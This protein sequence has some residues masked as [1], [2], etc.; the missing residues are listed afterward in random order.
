MDERICA[1][2]GGIVG[3]AD[4]ACCHCGTLFRAVI[5]PS[6]SGLHDFFRLL[7]GAWALALPVF[8]LY[9]GL[10][11][12]H[13]LGDFAAYL[14]S[15]VYFIPWIVG[16]ISLVILTWLTGE[17]AGPARRHPHRAARIRS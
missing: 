3:A 4:V 1:N 9:V 6:G 5:L 17:R 13:G 10:T 16:I 12:F 8:C 15:I 14:A 2:C 11:A 7:L